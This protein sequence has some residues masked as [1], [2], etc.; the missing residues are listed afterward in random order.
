MLPIVSGVTVTK[1]QIFLYTLGLIPV[2]LLPYAAGVGGVFYAAAAIV[3]TLVFIGYAVAVYRAEDQ[4]HGPARRM[5]RYSLLY[6]FLLFAVLS[7]DHGLAWFA[8]RF[9]QGG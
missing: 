1:Q 4:D 9:S 8:F 7:V 3:L 5:F 2:S 6:L